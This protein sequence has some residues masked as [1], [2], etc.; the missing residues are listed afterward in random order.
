[1][2]I[3][4]EDIPEQKRIDFAGLFS[5]ISAGICFTAMIIAVLKAIF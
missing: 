5:E 2:E 3:D 1:M 4:E